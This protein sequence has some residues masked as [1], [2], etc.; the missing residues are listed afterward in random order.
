MPSDRHRPL[1]L[2]G[3]NRISPVHAPTQSL[4][5]FT[6]VRVVI[7]QQH[8]C[9]AMASNL[10]QF[11]ELKPIC[12]GHCDPFCAGGMLSRR[13]A[14]CG[15]WRREDW[16]SFQAARRHIDS[17]KRLASALLLASLFITHANS[18]DIDINARI[19]SFAF[20]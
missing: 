17:C 18:I 19:E 3:A 13:L 16:L 20:P 6:G 15:A 10:C 14:G 4:R 1:T 9:V 8:S 7:P 2:L 11:M 5:K 12:Q